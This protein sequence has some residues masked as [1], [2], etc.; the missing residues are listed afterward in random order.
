MSE[1]RAG[2]NGR[3]ANLKWFGLRER[4][5]SLDGL[6]QGERLRGSISVSAFGIINDRVFRVGESVSL[7]VPNSLIDGFP[8]G[9]ASARRRTEPI[10]ESPQVYR[11]SF[12]LN[13]LGVWRWW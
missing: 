3:A 13:N 12:P 7:N 10:R 8:L 1:I 4:Q 6:T 2:Y 9:F 11:F 5:M